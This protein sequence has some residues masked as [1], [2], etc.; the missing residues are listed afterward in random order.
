MS[1][2]ISLVGIA[3]IGGAL[4]ACA[5]AVTV[6]P[7]YVGSYDPNILTYQARQGAMKTEIFGNPFNAPK[8]DL[9]NAVTDTMSGA[10][11]GRPVQFATAVPPENRSPYRVVLV[12]NPA[13][14]LASD[15]LCQASD[16]P[17]SGP[18]PTLRMEAALC[19]DGEALTATGG[20]VAGVQSAD[21]PK[22]RTLVRQFALALFPFEDPNRD[23]EDRDIDFPAD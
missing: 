4:A 10:I 3:L 2:L 15:D 21:D 20:T 13:K 6:R 8:S 16:H 9:D 7:A 23:N 12:V 14:T 5:D 22:F 18:A 19:A 17:T 1:R 11:F